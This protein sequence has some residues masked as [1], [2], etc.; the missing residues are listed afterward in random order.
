MF[1]YLISIKSHKLDKGET[2]ALKRD[3][4]GGIVL[5]GKNIL[6]DEQIRKLIKDIKTVR[7]SCLVAVDEEGGIVSRFSHIFPS[8]SQAYLSAQREFDFLTLNASRFYNERAKFL[9]SLGVDINLAPVADIAFD[10]FSALF[11]RSYGSDPQ[12]VAN[13]V[14]LCIQQQKR[15]SLLSCVKHFPGLGRTTVDSHQETP[16]IDVSFEDWKLSD[17]IPFKAAVNAGVEA[18]LVGHCLYPQIDSKVTS[19]SDVWINRLLR[20]DLGFGGLV[21]IDDIRMSGFPLEEGRREEVEKTFADLG[22]SFVIDT[23]YL[24]DTSEG[25][26]VRKI[27]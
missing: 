7:E 9:K 5:Y 25:P 20:K 1:K 27:T 22:V 26:K 10:E 14:V 4:V 16:R 24:E 15:E 11:K 13:L 18:V 19:I 3:E 8:L 2:A 12:K 17:T 23:E 6:T 21:I